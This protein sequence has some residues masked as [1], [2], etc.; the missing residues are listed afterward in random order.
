MAGDGVPAWGTTPR[1][2][3]SSSNGRRCGAPGATVCFPES[4][5]RKTWARPRG[6]ALLAGEPPTPRQRRHSALQRRGDARPGD[7]AGGRRGHEVE[8]RQQDRHTA[9]EAQAPAPPPGGANSSGADRAT[10][11]RGLQRARP[12][13][14]AGCRSK[15]PTTARTLRGV[16]TTARLCREPRHVGQQFARRRRSVVD[17]RAWAVAQAGRRQTRRAPSAGPDVAQLQHSARQLG[18][19]TRR[20]ELRRPARARPQAM[21]SRRVRPRRS[22][23]G[24]S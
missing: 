9:S 19:E 22:V 10:A 23:S 7:M 1:S 8:F 12:P 15:I 11:R 24:N 2:L 16:A 20:A 21:T 5:A 4:L 18:A 6:G 17:Q 14:P 13:R 3:N